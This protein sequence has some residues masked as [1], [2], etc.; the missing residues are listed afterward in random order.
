MRVDGLHRFFKFAPWQPEHLAARWWCHYCDAL[1]P[2]VA[3]EH[4]RQYTLRP[5]RRGRPRKT[6]VT[7]FL[8][9]DDSTH[10]KRKGKKMEG[11]GVHYSTTEGKPIKGHS[12]FAALHVLLGRRHPLAPQLYRQ[13]ATCER[14][15]VPFKSK[16]DLAEELIRTFEPVPGT[17]THLIFDS[18]YACRRVW[19]ATLARGWAVTGG[20]KANR[21]I[22]LVEP[23]QGRVYLS[24]P[25]YAARL[26]A[27]DYQQV[28]WPHADST[29]FLLLVPPESFH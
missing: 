23:E 15:G 13:K 22:R 1:G 14:D 4:A 12:L 20:L 26:S 5:K 2:L 7:G 6:V 3:A 21:K 17:R 10:A 11:L 27:E 28:P 16:V 25:K 19:R 24:L 18:W 9:L 29:P 8:I